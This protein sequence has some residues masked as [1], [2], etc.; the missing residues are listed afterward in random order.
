MGHATENQTDSAE[1]LPAGLL[2]RPVEGCN[3]RGKTLR[4]HLGARM[5]H[6][7]FLRHFG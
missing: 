5:T 7:V 3:L 4:E 6:V 1:R 2:D